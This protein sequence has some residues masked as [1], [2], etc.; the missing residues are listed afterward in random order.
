[1]KVKIDKIIPN[2]QQPRQFFDP[3]KLEEL[4][5]SIREN[6]LIQPIVV[7]KALNND[8]YVLIDGERR[9]RA[10]KM[11]GKKEIEAVIREP[12]QK[13]EK[14]RLLEAL[15][16]NLQREDLTPVEEGEAYLQLKQMGMSHVRIGNMVGKSAPYILTRLKLM[17]MDEEIQD[18]VGKNLLPVDMR[19]S[20]SLS[21]IEDKDVRI[22]MAVKLARPGIKIATIERA[23]QTYNNSLTDRIKDQVPAIAV[24]EKRRKK[25]VRIAAWDLLSQVGLLPEWKYVVKAS[26]KVCSACSLHD[27]ASPKICGECPAVIIVQEMMALSEKG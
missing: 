7:E 1:M 14:T 11:A 26:E 19:V 12:S 21:S 16:A 24:A 4:A 2:P 27:M 18:L 17:E 6:G 9:L 25:Q 22:K 23:C 13:D 15:V 5:N 20:S 8:Q 10:S 3:Q